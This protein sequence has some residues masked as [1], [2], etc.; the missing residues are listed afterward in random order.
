MS[1]ASLSKVTVKLPGIEGEW[2]ADK[3]QQTAAWEM[4]VELITR[5]SVQPLGHDE[6]LLREAL[7]SLHAL[8]G[9]TRRILR[10]YG[11][12]VARPERKKYLSFGGIAVDVMNVWLRPFLSKWHPRL[13]DH[14][15]RRPAD[16]SPHQHEAAWAEADALRAALDELRGKLILYADL[17][18][19]ACE[20]PSLHLR[21]E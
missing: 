13:Q 9:E 19:E 11:P 2:V 20:I 17:L 12:D 15:S 8:F 18:A 7:A 1:K 3:A 14:E 6:G 16:A 5:V 21:P 10:T 4:Y